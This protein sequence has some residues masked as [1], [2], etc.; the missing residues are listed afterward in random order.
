M[1]TNELAQ[2]GINLTNK[3]SHCCPMCFVGKEKLTI[4]EFSFSNLKKVID[5]VLE[6]NPKIGFIFLGG[7]PCEYSKISELLKYCFKKNAYT[8]VL[9]NTLDFNGSNKHDYVKYISNLSTTIHGKNSKIHDAFC[10]KPGAYKKVVQNLL[11]YQSLKNENQTIGIHFTLMKHNYK[12]VYKSIKNLIKLGVKINFINIQRIMPFGYATEKE[13]LSLKEI[14]KAFVQIKKVNERLKVDTK[15]LDAFP[16]CIIPEQYH[17]YMNKCTCGT[18][19]LKMDA[20]GNFGR[21]RVT[22]VFDLGNIFK[23][24]MLTI[25][26][27]DELKSFRTKT[28]LDEKCHICPK[29]DKCGGGCPISCGSCKLSVDMLRSNP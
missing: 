26:K 23:Q 4:K 27:A 11:E 12:T 22:G 17:K 21:C 25:L 2:I 7:D 10:G 8:S 24:D 9:S 6:Y 20:D 13:V 3:C 1:D 29:L 14:L 5:K 18:K 28:Y 19:V 16:M 15:T